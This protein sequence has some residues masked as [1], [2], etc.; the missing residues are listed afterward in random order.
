MDADDT[1]GEISSSDKILKLKYQ[2]KILKIV[3]LY[4]LAYMKLKLLAPG[5]KGK[6]LFAHFN[7]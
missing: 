2:K 5:K 7:T 6:D 4:S 3:I 1:A